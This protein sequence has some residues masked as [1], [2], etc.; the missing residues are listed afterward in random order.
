MKKPLSLS[1]IMML[2]LIERYGSF[3]LAAEQL[4]RSVS[5]LS[6]QIQKLEQELDLMIFDRSGHKAKFTAAGQLLLE[7]GRQLLLAADDLVLEANALNNGWESK[8]TI[9][10]DGIIGCEA[11]FPLVESLASIANTQLILREEVLAGCWEALRYEHADILIATPSLSAPV[12]TKVAQVGKI[13]MVWV[14]A[15]QH[16]IHQAF[17]P[18]TPETRQSFRIISVADSARELPPLNHNILDGQQFLSVS[19]FHS[20]VKAIIRGLG[21][22]T[23]PY[24]MIEPYLHSKELVMI[25]PNK[26]IDVVMAWKRDP[27]GQAK[28]WC[29][30]QLKKSLSAQLKHCEINTHLVQ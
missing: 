11:L 17:D 29:I 24:F 20:K 14:A 22:G 13:D 28:S 5:S 6:Y 10:Y 16:P 23:L 15:P 26:T 25:G 18:L 27:M 30:N 12:E 4:N 1:S 19:D 2:D 9:A 7:R 3:S 21:I 8:L